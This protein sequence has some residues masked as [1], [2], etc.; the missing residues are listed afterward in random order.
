MHFNYA[1]DLISSFSMALWK[2]FNATD[3]GSMCFT[4]PT[5]SPW[6]IQLI[7]PHSQC[8]PLTDGWKFRKVRPCWLKF[9]KYLCL[10]GVCL[11]PYCSL[12]QVHLNASLMSQPSPAYMNH[13]RFLS[14][15]NIISSFKQLIK[16]R[17]FCPCNQ[18]T[19]F[20]AGC[21]RVWILNRLFTR[22][23]GNSGSVTP[24]VQ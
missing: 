23:W 5:H 13:L 8:W 2:K 4:F 16:R 1:L 22:G 15:D 24:S 17:L 10:D 7:N 19:V 11:K 12:V 14:F 18:E 3:F 21:F 6:W 20:W 9:S